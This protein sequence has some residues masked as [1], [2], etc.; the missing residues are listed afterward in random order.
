[1][2]RALLTFLSI[3][4]TLIVAFVL[5]WV[6]LKQTFFDIQSHQFVVRKTKQNK[7]EDV[8]SQGAAI[9]NQVRITYGIF[10]G[11]LL[12]WI[13]VSIF[14]KLS[15]ALIVFISILITVALLYIAFFSMCLSFELTFAFANKNWL[16][17]VLSHQSTGGLVVTSWQNDIDFNKVVV[18]KAAQPNVSHPTNKSELIEK[19]M[20]LEQDL[21]APFLTLNQSSI[22]Q[23]I[24]QIANENPSIITLKALED[25]LTKEFLPY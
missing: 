8:E 7:K 20:S 17:K 18:W 4:I 24:L 25:H 22:V 19:C 14:L 12:L 21:L 6:L 16:R 1:M 13:G 23:I 9:K 11:L 5:D 15:D 10:A 2:N 3:F